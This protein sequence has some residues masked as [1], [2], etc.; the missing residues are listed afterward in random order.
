LVASQA[1]LRTAALQFSAAPDV[2]VA[3]VVGA[4]SH[5]QIAEDYN[6]LQAKNPSE[7]WA[8]LKQQDLI[9]S[10]ASLPAAPALAK[11]ILRKCICRR[12]MTMERPLL[13]DIVAKVPEGAAANTRQRTNQ[14]TIADQECFK[15]A[16]RIVCKFGA[17]RRGPPH[18]CS[19]AAPTG[20]R[21]GGPPRKK[22]FA[23]ISA[24]GRHQHNYSINSSALSTINGGVPFLVSIVLVLISLW[25]RGSFVSHPNLRDRIPGK[26]GRRQSPSSLF[27]GHPGRL[28]MIEDAFNRWWERVEKPPDSTLTIPAHF[29]DAATAGTTP[30]PQNCERGH[31]TGRPGRATM[32]A[33]RGARDIIKRN[34]L[35]EKERPVEPLFFRFYGQG[36]RRPS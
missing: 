8:E 22:T 24:N 27:Q 29:H 35:L 19:I 20:Q 30:R 25:I 15:R 31:A 3:L 36:C 2:A 26:A 6:S 16:T 33:L 23:T 21:I 9:E 18:H 11:P 7:F 34:R 4:R 32:S 5:Q 1:W 10:D 13:A 28:I 14:A 17:W 12:M